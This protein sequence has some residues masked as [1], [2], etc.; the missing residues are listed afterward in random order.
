MSDS[1]FQTQQNKRAT[2]SV[3]LLTNKI[4]I[5]NKNEIRKS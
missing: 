5:L 4:V 3:S 2:T 1:F